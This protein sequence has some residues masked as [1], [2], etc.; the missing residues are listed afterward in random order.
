MPEDLIAPLPE[1]PVPPTDIPLPIPAKPNRRIAVYVFGILFA[2]GLVSAVLFFY[3]KRPKT[4]DLKYSP[5]SE[6]TSESAFET[7][8]KSSNYIS[9]VESKDGLKKSSVRIY[10]PDAK[11]FLTLPKEL[12]EENVIYTLGPWSP[13]SNYLPI[14][15]STMDDSRTQTLYLYNPSLN[16]LKALIHL[17]GEAAQDYKLNYS[18]MMFNS[19]WLN[20]TDYVYYNDIGDGDL[21]NSQVIN[22]NGVDETRQL[23]KELLFGTKLPGIN[24]IY[25]K[26]V[27]ISGKSYTITTLGKILGAV[28]GQLVM[29]DAQASPYDLSNFMY[30]PEDENMLKMEDLLDEKRK[31]G[32]S[33]DEILEF[34]LDELT[35]KGD[36]QLFLLDPETNVRKNIIALNST[37]FPIVSDAQ[38]DSN[39]KIVFR[40]NNTVLGSTSY[41][42]AEVSLTDPAIKVLI[43]K[44]NASAGDNSPSSILE[45][46]VYFFLSSD[47]NWIVYYHDHDVLAFNRKT[48]QESP[49]ICDG[50][51]LSINGNTC[52]GLKVNNSKYSY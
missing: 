43:S 39:N 17:E 19:K 24:A 45:D 14:L 27:N 38:L 7:Y 2:L 31:Q 41:E 1:A 35:P 21:L 40:R 12:S 23:P 33:E 11:S 18:S 30:N 47:N 52:S 32:M 44:A 10:N 5:G 42:I 6:P 28:N 22:I 16:E 8:L 36:T 50:E 29:L 25:D 48:M 15:K 37:D 9:F 46:D 51:D 20:N 26:S 13:D 3:I 49:T 4:I 34:I